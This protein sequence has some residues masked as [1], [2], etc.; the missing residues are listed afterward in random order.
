M[1]TAAQLLTVFPQCHDPNLWAARIRQVADEFD[2]STKSRLS[3]FVGQCGH[4]SNQ[5]NRLRENLSY[6][7]LGLMRTWPKRF[8][9]EES[10]NSFVRNPQ[11]LANF[12]Y[13]NRLG[14]SGYD[15]GDGFRF[16]GGGLIQ[17]T[18]RDNYRKASAA[19]GLPLEAQPAKIE[20]PAI[21]A[22]VA[23]WFWQSHGCNEL[24]D[25]NDFEG[26][27]KAINGPAML[28]LE[29]RRELAKKI[30]EVLP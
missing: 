22:R 28:G 1:I 27:T 13:A 18:G 12:V 3:I 5:F 26:I 19:L 4:E 10:T 20:D 7:K 16:R 29:E 15:S 11:R 6:S 2:L 23:G 17:L 14:N 25:A 24:A 30:Y 21:A 8:P 9:T